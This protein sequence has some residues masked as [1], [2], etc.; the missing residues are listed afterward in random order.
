MVQIQNC[1]IIPI[2]L[3][4]IFFLIPDLTKVHSL[5]LT[6]TLFSLLLASCFCRMSH[7]WGFFVSLFFDITEQ[8]WHECLIGDTVFSLTASPRKPTDQAAS[9]LGKLDGSFGWN[10]SY[11]MAPFCLQSREI[12][13]EGIC[14][15]HVKI[16]SHSHPHHLALAS[17]GEPTP[18]L[19]KRD[20]P[21]LSAEFLENSLPFLNLWW[22]L[23]THESFFKLCHVSK[24]MPVI[25]FWYSHYSNF[26]TAVRPPSNWLLGPLLWAPPCE[27]PPCSPARDVPGSP[28]TRLA[29][30]GSHFFGLILSLYADKLC[31][32][33]TAWF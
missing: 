16:L 31:H 28:W 29:P 23:Y 3:Q 32:F 24:H 2:G 27:C 11:Q 7:R 22:L 10:A 12:T 21:N 1:V 15:K 9:F 26:A 17:T 18:G 25:T 6:L 30:T 5:Y 14:W 33:L 13:Y 19:L 4:L 20:S 8:V